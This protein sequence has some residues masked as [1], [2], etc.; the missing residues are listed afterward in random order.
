FHLVPHML[1]RATLRKLH[2]LIKIELEPVRKS[3]A[4]L[5]LKQVIRFSFP[6][7]LP[8][9]P[10]LE[11]QLPRRAHINPRR[12]KPP[13]RCPFRLLVWADGLILP[14]RLGWRLGFGDGDRGQPD[15][16][17][18]LGETRTD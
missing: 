12:P 2:V 17:L 1:K 3:D 14:G 13:P 10:L 8:L 4:H 7:K 5:R 18:V 15:G 16:A 11:F 9:P 6:W